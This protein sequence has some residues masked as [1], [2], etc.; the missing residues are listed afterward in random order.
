MRTSIHLGL[1]ALL[2]ACAAP[3]GPLDG[4]AAAALDPAAALAAALASLTSADARQARVRLTALPSEH[5]NDKQRAIR[6][7]VLARLGDQP[8]GPM[9]G[10]QA[11]ASAVA[12]VIAAHHRYWRAAMTRTLTPAAAEHALLDDLRAVPGVQGADVGAV[13]DSARALV[14]R[15]G[16]FALAGVTRPL[17]E[18]MVWRTQSSTL[19]RVALPGGAVDVRVT[20]LDGFINLGW[21]GW[22]TCERSHTGGWV[23][24]EGM[25]VVAPAWD[26][27]SEGYRVSLLAHEAQ[28]FSDQA[29]WPKLS[30]AD[31]EYRA[32]L[33]EIAL[34]EQTLSALIARFAAEAGRDRA[35]PH[36][37][38]SHWLT[39]RL[40]GV[41]SGGDAALRAAALAA[42]DAHTQAL[43]RQGAQAVTALPD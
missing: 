20:M 21:L 33:V 29:R 37:F 28:H 4:D 24:P 23:T 30:S 40:K 36:A 11:L 8:L 19:Q 6:D 2:C 13:T 42:L 34:A 41:A 9:E 32:K 31:L 5:L 7:C 38:A 22:A 3:A 43:A 10:E 14:E 39:Q 1:A 25:M 27:S 16:L 12:Q 26:L 15:H 35:S 17:R 18:L